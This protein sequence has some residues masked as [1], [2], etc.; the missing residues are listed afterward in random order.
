MMKFSKEWSDQMMT[1]AVPA[2][3]KKE[4]LTNDARNILVFSLDDFM[5]NS[6]IFKNKK[7]I[8]SEF[9]D[10]ILRIKS[11][12]ADKPSSTPR[13]K[14]WQIGR[15]IVNTRKKIKEKYNVDIT[16]IIEA[17]AI[18]LELSDSFLSYFVKFSEFSLKRQ[19]D[20]SIPWSSYIEALKLPNKIEFNRCIQLIKEG[21]LKS[22]KEIREYVKERNRLIRSCRKL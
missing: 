4:K 15:M 13:K 21:K 9:E 14:I 18:N 3:I 16:N 1:K 11:L 7:E 20:E 12:M 5:N 19:I 6:T 17:V 2:Q 10:L 22:S 8:I